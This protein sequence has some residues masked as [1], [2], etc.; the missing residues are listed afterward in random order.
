MPH[1]ARTHSEFCTKLCLLCLAKGPC[2]LPI[3]KPVNSTAKHDLVSY[4]RSSWWPDYN[5]EN[6]KLS[7][8][9]CM[10]CRLKV[11]Q[12]NNPTVVNPPPLPPKLMYEKIVF[13]PETRFNPQCDCD[14]CLHGRFKFSNLGDPINCKVLPQPQTGNYSRKGVKCSRKAGTER[15]C[16]KCLQVIGRGLR[17]ACTRTKK[18]DNLAGLVKATSVKTKSRVIAGELSRTN[19]L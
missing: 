1:T 8:V 12:H 9:I 10:N 14:I 15:R 11:I 2:L 18:L 16:N 19:L 3:K 4:I 6:D 17:H 7:R 5:P 13:K